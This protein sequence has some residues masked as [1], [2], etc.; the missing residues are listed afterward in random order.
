[1]YIQGFFTMLTS[2]TVVFSK[3][4]IERRLLGLD[5]AFVVDDNSYGVEVPTLSYPIAFN[6]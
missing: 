5:G 6:G 3:S 4:I 2:I 1:M